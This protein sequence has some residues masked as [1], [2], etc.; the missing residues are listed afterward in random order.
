PVM[1]HASMRQVPT[2]RAL[3]IGFRGPR[4][5]RILAKAGAMDHRT[6]DDGSNPSGPTPTPREAYTDHAALEVD[7]KPSLS[8]TGTAMLAE[9]SLMPESALSRPKPRLLFCS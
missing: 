4:R 9:A 7:C 6:N 3:K 2:F 5:A 8:H 1:P